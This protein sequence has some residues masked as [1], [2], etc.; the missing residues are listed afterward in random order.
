MKDWVGAAPMIIKE[1]ASVSWRYI[2]LNIDPVLN[3]YYWF[4]F[5][6][7]FQN[8][9]SCPDCG[10]RIYHE[11]WKVTPQLAEARYVF[12]HCIKIHPYVYEILVHTHSTKM[13]NSITVLTVSSHQHFSSN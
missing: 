13:L 11:K 2:I 4:E 7:I 9:K 1:Q 8:G 6:K 12:I 10:V 5:K 3:F